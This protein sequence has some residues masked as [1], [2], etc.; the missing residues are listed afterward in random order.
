[1]LKRPKS[2]I[3]PAYRQQD[4]SAAHDKRDYVQTKPWYVR[5]WQGIKLNLTRKLP[6]Q[7]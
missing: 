2:Q 5:V 7:Q 3:F 4:I 1:M 6:L